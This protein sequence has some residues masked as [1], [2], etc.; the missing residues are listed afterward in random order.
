MHQGPELKEAASILWLVPERLGDAIMGTAAL[1]LLKTARPDLQVDLLAFSDTSVG[2]Y[3]HNPFINRVYLNPSRRM[4][5]Q[6]E[7]R[8]TLI[9]HIHPDIDHERLRT[10]GIPWVA[11][12]D[13]GMTHHQAFVQQDFIRK[14]LD[15][16]DTPALDY[17]LNHTPAEHD[18]VRSMLLRQQYNPASDIL[19]GCSIG[20]NRLAHRGLKFWK[21]LAHPKVWPMNHLQSFDV[22]LRSQHPSARLVLIGTGSEQRLAGGF[23]RKSPRTINM[24]SGLSIPQLTALVTQ[25]NAVISADTGLLHVACA[26]KKP[27][28]ALHGS[29]RPERSGPFPVRPWHRII[30]A[31]SMIGI[32]PEQVLAELLA[33]MTAPA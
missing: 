22:L 28:L 32:F 19:I 25:L 16:P 12:S 33:L 9:V 17:T 23:C 29:T 6:L 10:F 2:V 24:T 21:P 26:A 4:V 1:H 18:V 11:P 15:L 14:Q 20:C 13:P 3:R 27:L 7:K 31:E 30:R 8:H 5:R